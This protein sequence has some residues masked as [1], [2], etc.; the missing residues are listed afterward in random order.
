MR[1]TTKK[2]NFHA[3]HESLESDQQVQL[4]EAQNIAKIFEE[5]GAF[6]MSVISRKFSSQPN[7]DI[8]DLFHDFFISLAEKPI[9]RDVK[10]VKS[11]LHKSINNDIMDWYRKARNHRIRNH[12]H[13]SYRNLQQLLRN[14][15]P[16]VEI[17]NKDTFGHINRMIGRHL[18]E[19]EANAVKQKL[20]LGNSTSEGARNL[21]IKKRSFSRYLCA[22]LKRLRKLC[23]EL[24]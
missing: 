1:K 5:H 9:P 7:M 23:T 8:E 16:S 14:E 4:S 17:E 2:E 15:D 13:Q 6:L 3:Q 20:L 10:C 22:G 19:H 18:P 12:K 21:N 24:E 11:Y